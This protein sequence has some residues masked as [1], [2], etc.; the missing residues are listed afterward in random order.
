MRIFYAIRHSL[1]PAKYYGGLRFIPDWLRESPVGRAYRSHR[2]L[3]IVRQWTEEDTSRQKFYS[4]FVQAGQVV[5]DIGAN[6]GNR[7]KVFRRLGARVI[8]V[9]PQPRLARALKRA[10]A[11]DRGVCI[12]E[13]AVGSSPGEAQMFIAGVHALSSLSARWI[14]NVRASGRFQDVEWKQTTRVPVTTL[15][16]LIAHYGAP[17]FIKID[18]EGFEYQVLAG[19]HTSVSAL[20]FEFTPE[21][22]S[23]AHSCV[24]YLEDLGM[25]EFNFAEGEATEL[26]FQCWLTG[27]ELERVLD[28]TRDLAIFTLAGTWR[29]GRHRHSIE[30][31][32]TSPRRTVREFKREDSG[33]AAIDKVR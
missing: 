19:L 27:R 21:M 31:S 10:Y 15:D 9:E 12:I 3:A 6:L 16:I 13:A 32:M 5:F 20:S 8:A 18:V 22:S 7:T 2:D 29:N 17:A 23:V 33:F 24:S 30:F 28:V 14:E 26:R 4:Q 11:R 25:R 1:D